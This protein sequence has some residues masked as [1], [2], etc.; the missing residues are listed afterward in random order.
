MNSAGLP[1]RA[2]CSLMNRGAQYGHCVLS[3]LTYSL[4]FGVLCSVGGE[5]K[6]RFVVLGKT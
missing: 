5:N 1:P 6:G 2:G 3:K 4:T